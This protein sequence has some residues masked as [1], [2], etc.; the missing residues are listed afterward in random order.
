[1]IGSAKPVAPSKVVV[2]ISMPPSSA[3]KMS[4][5]LEEIPACSW[6]I[7]AGGAWLW[8]G[9]ESTNAIHHI[10]NI[11]AALGPEGGSAVVYK[12]PEEIK[13]GAGLFTSSVS[14][15]TALQDRVRESFDPKNLFNPAKLGASM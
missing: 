10:Q 1:M 7:D 6:Y 3:Y 15:L 8:L 13:H 12:A 14:A 4:C 2:K 9:L 11:R 5:L